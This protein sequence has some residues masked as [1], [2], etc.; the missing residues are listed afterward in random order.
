MRE[1]GKAGQ[2]WV[3]RSGPNE[4][5]GILVVHVDVLAD[6][7][8]QC[9]HTSE[10]A[11]PNALVGDRGEPAFP[12]VD[13]GCVGGS[14]VPMKAGR[15]GEPLSD[16]RRFVGAVVIPDNVHFQLRRHLGLDPV[17]KGAKFR[18]AVAAG[19]LTDHAAGLQFQRGK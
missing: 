18:G 14:E 11:S 12:Q 13:P 17:A 1:P 8:F 3:G 9:F 10:D 4:R 5:L 2:N 6:G 7:R 15:L 16:D 19:Q